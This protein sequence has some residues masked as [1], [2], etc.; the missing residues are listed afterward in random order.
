[1]TRDGVIGRD[2]EELFER[3]IDALRNEHALV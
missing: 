1:V 3:P 2:R